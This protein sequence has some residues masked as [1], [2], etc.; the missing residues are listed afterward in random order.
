MASGGDQYIH[1]A[2][3]NLERQ[4]ILNQCFRHSSAE[5]FVKSKL[6]D[7]STTISKEFR[8]LE[9]GCGA[10]VTTLD[11]SQVLS[12]AKIVAIDA[13]ADLIEIA[14]RNLKENHPDLVS[15]INFT[16]K[17]GEEAA[18]EWEGTFDA[19]WMRFVLVHVPDPMQLVQA[20]VACLKPGGTLLIEDCD[21][22][23]AISDPPLYANTF[24]HEAHIAASLK[25]GADIR[26]GPW[27]GRYLVEAGLQDIH[28]D[29]FV[30]IFGKGPTLTPWC[31]Q[32]ET[33]L[34]PVD[35]TTRHFDLGLQLLQMSLESLAPKLLEL[36]ICTQGELEKA[37]DS[38]ASVE[39]LD[40]Q[41][42]S[43]PGGKIF[44]WWGKKM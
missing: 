5:A 10:G 41:L 43:V 44:Q 14:R 19:V 6:V 18:E 42:F 28:G 2:N 9:I 36:E 17:S 35:S 21:A 16:T 30:P 38:I 8:V 31:R 23:G 7:Q 33:L 11:L 15:R 39:N 4:N 20:A 25:L 26:R 29:S 3:E 40:Y 13:N 27:I 22:T 12:A 37:Y 32:P 24:I 34:G 1:N